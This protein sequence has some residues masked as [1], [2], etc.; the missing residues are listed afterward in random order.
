MK[1]FKKDPLAKR[2]II[3]NLNHTTLMEWEV[4]QLIAL[5]FEVFIPKI[6]PDGPSGRT[7]VVTDRYDRT[8]SIP[9]NE[10]DAINN[11]NF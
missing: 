1:H 10:L 7:A 11:V 8:L 6:L 2:R 5:G 4:P 3:W 9:K